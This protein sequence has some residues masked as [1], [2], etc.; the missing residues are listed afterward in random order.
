MSKG[1]PAISRACWL[2]LLAL[3]LLWRDN[4]L[5]HVIALLRSLFCSCCDKFQRPRAIRAL[6]KFPSH[7]RKRIEYWHPSADIIF[8]ANYKMASV[9]PKG[10]SLGSRLSALWNSPT[11]WRRCYDVFC[12]AIFSH[13]IAALPRCPISSSKKPIRAMKPLPS[14]STAICPLTAVALSGLPISP[15]CTARKIGVRSAICVLSAHCGCPALFKLYYL[16]MPPA[17]ES[18]PVMQLCLARAAFGFCWSVNPKTAQRGSG[19]HPL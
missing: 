6:A 10:A 3:I 18:V 13:V 7:T 11:G 4:Q 2:Q 5:S 8:K 9:A 12:C 1:Y 14:P 19:V 15:S 16:P 17:A